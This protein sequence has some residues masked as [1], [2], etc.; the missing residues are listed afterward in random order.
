MRT[1][2]EVAFFTRESIYY[3]A[4]YSLWMIAE[5][6]IAA[7]AAVTSVWLV[8]H[9]AVSIARAKAEVEADLKLRRE[10]QNNEFKLERI[11][12]ETAAMR[13]DADI[14]AF[15]ANAGQT[16]EMGLEGIINAVLSNP[17]VLE[18]LLASPEIAKFLGGLGGAGKA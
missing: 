17:A 2:G 7:V 12:A 3:P 11:K 9:T 6:G 1:G 14:T 5:V 16:P 4:A 18:K 13:A 10:A 15:A 8:G